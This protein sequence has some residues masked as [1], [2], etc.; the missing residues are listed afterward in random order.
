[1]EL[2]DWSRGDGGHY[3]KPV[4]VLPGMGMEALRTMF[5]TGEPNDM[6]FVLFST[7]GIHGSYLTIEDHELEP[8][9]EYD[10][11]EFQEHE[12][13]FLIVQPRIVAMRY[14]KVNPKT[15]DDYEFLK[16]LRQASW[17]IVSKIG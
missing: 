16:K 6:N 1:M 7:S 3:S 10:D 2:W 17:D 15:P 14:G 5:P 11:G 8:E 9:F 12:I 13:T 4:K